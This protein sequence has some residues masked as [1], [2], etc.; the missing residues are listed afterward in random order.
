MT[1]I[2]LND[3]RTLSVDDFDDGAWIALAG[4][5]Y[6]VSTPLTKEQASQLIATLQKVLESA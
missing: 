6:H 4:H 5:G 2:E 1:H 3:R